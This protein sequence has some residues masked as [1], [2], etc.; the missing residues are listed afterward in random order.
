MHLVGYNDYYFVM[1]LTG[2]YF[3]KISGVMFI[4]LTEIWENIFFSLVV[5]I[6]L[7]LL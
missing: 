2:V 3:Y 5:F 7:V 1:N 4:V 6:H